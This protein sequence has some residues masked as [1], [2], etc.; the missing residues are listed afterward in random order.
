MMAARRRRSAHV[1]AGSLALQ[2]AVAALGGVVAG[3]EG[4]LPT[5]FGAVALLS[6]S[7]AVLEWVRARLAEAVTLV[8]MAASYLLILATVLA[9]LWYVAPFVA[10]ATIACLF[11]LAHRYAVRDEARHQPRVT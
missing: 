1:L 4:P 6:F 8:A 2:G 3:R 9:G 5:F 11:G 7:A 10:L